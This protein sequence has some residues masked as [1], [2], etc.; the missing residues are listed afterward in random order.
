MKG[1]LWFLAVIAAIT[2]L[3]FSAEALLGYSILEFVFELMLVVFFSILFAV[4]L[5]WPVAAILRRVLVQRLWPKAE[6]YFHLRWCLMWAFALLLIPHLWMSYKLAPLKREFTKVCNHGGY[7]VRF[8]GEHADG[9][10][11]NEADFGGK[12]D[13]LVEKRVL[14]LVK[15]QYVPYFTG[16]WRFSESFPASVT[17]CAYVYTFL[18]RP[19]YRWLAVGVAELA[20]GVKLLPGELQKAEKEITGLPY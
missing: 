2:G 18:P 1:F 19:V 20:T 4:F 16:A 3:H 15:Y 11:V 13:R 17:S 5:V 6:P 8:T 7:D 14:V 9:R 10:P 12:L